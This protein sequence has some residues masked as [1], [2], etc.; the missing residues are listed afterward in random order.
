MRIKVVPKGVLLEVR[1]EVEKC[2][3]TWIRFCVNGNTIQHWTETEVNSWNWFGSLAQVHTGDQSVLPGMRAKSFVGQSFASPL[4][5]PALKYMRHCWLCSKRLS[6]PIPC[7][8]G[9]H[10]HSQFC[11]T[12]SFAHNLCGRRGAWRHRPSL[13]VACVALGHIHVPCAWQVCHFWHWIWWCVWSPLVARASLGGT[14]GT[15]RWSPLT[16]HHLALAAST[17]HVCSRRGTWRH[18]PST[19]VASTC[20]LRGR[21]HLR[22]WAG[23]GGALGPRS[24]PVTLRHFAWQAWHLATYVTLM[25]FR[26][27]VGRDVNAHIHVNCSQK[28]AAMSVVSW[29]EIVFRKREKRACRARCAVARELDTET[30]KNT[31]CLSTPFPIYLIY[32]IYR[33]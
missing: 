8:R 11:H 32:L 5:P 10:T 31:R 12:Q 2:Q 33:S 14:Y 24:S 7:A 28:L 23:S 25:M 22:H 26:G 3:I 16:P 13:R 17:F 1:V 20:L 18:P 19:C 9:V 21:R 29:L 30:L 15:G 4:C 6:A 27:G